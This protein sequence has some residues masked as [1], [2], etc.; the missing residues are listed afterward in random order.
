MQFQNSGYKVPPNVAAAQKTGRPHPVAKNSIN[1]VH[2]TNVKKDNYKCR[3]F[4]Q[5]NYETDYLAKR[6]KCFLCKKPSHMTRDCPI[7]K[8]SSSYQ[9]VNRKPMY[10]VNTASL[11]V[12]SEVDTSHLQV[13]RPPTDNRKAIIPIS[14]NILNAVEITINGYKAHALI[15]PCTINGDLISA[16]FCF[17]KQI[18]T[19]DMDAKSL[20]TAIKGSRSTITKQAT[21]EL[22]I[23]RNK[24]S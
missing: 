11:S 3:T 2:F 7:R 9:Q 1:C 15:D 13:R 23:H 24:I 18:P 10:Q 6:G 21:V 8:F 12:E 20:E 4:G 5:L 19:E 14:Q 16:N 22:N 17:L